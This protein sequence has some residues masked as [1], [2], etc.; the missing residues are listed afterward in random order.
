MSCDTREGEQIRLSKAEAQVRRWKREL[1]CRQ[2][3]ILAAQREITALEGRRR[4]LGRKISQ[5]E[6]ERRSH[7]N[8]LLTAKQSLLNE[9]GAIS[10]EV[11]VP[12]H[13]QAIWRAHQNLLNLN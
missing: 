13:L 9:L 12:E 7:M 8:S 2:E 6:K 4:E 1:R 11:N 5:L 10:D 3:D